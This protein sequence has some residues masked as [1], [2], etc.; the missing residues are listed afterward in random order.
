MP[1]SFKRGFST[2]KPTRVR[3]HRLRVERVSRAQAASRLQR[4]WRARKLR[5]T[6]RRTMRQAIPTDYWQESYQMSPSSTT[7]T[8]H[9]VMVL[10]FN[11]QVPVP[12]TAHREGDKVFWKG[13]TIKWSIHNQ[14][15]YAAGNTPGKVRFGLVEARGTAMEAAQLLYNPENVAAGVNDTDAIMNHAKVK[16]LF[17]KTITMGDSDAYDK[18]GYRDHQNVKT[19]TKCNQRR[20]FISNDPTSATRC[21]QR[22]WYTF[23]IASGFTA[24]QI[25]ISVDSS[26]SFKDLA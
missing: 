19:F 14:R 15:A 24:G 9:N 16:V 6:V 26:F 20:M 8:L 11:T 23:A 18:Q 25:R 1:T 3:I 4:V 12:Y 7:L 13:L 2:S 5:Q 10:P 21:T 22:N 17:D